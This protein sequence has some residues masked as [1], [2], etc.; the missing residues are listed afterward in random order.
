[1]KQEIIFPERSTSLRKNNSEE[2]VININPESFKEIFIINGKLFKTEAIK[3]K[4]LIIKSNDY[5]MIINKGKVPIELH[6]DIDIQN[7]QVIYNPYKY[8]NTEKI[9]FKAE[10]FIEKYNIPNNY[11]DTLPKW[12]SFKFT[13]PEYNMIFIRPEFGLSIQIHK[14]RNEYWEILEGKPIIINGNGVYYYVENGTKFE[15][16]INTYH[17]AINPNKEV[18]KYII[19]KERWDGKF[20][21]NDINRIFNPN[22]Y[23]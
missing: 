16:L 9:N 21:E 1:M 8:E 17:S 15:N 7:H 23:Y 11:T 18:D 12:Y 2:L 19:I 20:D 22:Q 13:Y 6:Y 4:D 14:D 10:Q 5:Y 3:E